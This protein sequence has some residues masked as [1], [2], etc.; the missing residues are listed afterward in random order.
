MSDEDRLERVLPRILEEQRQ[1]LSPVRQAEIDALVEAL[2][3]A[4]RVFFIG[5][6]RVGTATR[7]LAMRVA[8]FG[9]PAFWVP[10]DTTPAIGPG[11]LLI[12]N[13]GS[14]GS[15]S[16]LHVATQAAKA[17]AAVATITANPN[18]QIARLARTVLVLPAQTFKTDRSRWTSLLPMGSQFELALWILQDV[19][20]LSLMRRL[21]IDEAALIAR[22]RNLE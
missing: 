14:G 6:G 4:S 2:A 17:G 13:S 16:T 10:D 18:G 5:A 15:P 1:V 3:G 22:H 11:D 12:A 21:G 19:L 7:A 20:C 8:H 9:K